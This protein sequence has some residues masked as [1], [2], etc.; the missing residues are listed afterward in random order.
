MHPPK[1]AHAVTLPLTRYLRRPEVQRVTGLGQDSIYRGGREGWFPRPYKL[2]ERATGWREDE[3]RAWLESR[4][5]TN[6][7][8]PLT[9]PAIAG[10]A[11]RRRA[12]QNGEGAQ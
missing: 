4:P 5:E 8:Q 3:V 6:P 10:K 2:S 11:A 9:A 12:R 1:S 7:E